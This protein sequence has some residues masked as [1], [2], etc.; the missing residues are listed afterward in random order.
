MLLNPLSAS[1][2]NTPAQLWN[3][4]PSSLSSSLQVTEA[5]SPEETTFRG[6]K[7]DNI[8]DRV[9][10]PEGAAMVGLEESWL[11]EAIWRKN[12]TKK[13]GASKLDATAM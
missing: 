3:S 10:F 5:I 7:N 12:K 4:P 8:V 11:S 6:H 1:T 9:D 13:G 2:A